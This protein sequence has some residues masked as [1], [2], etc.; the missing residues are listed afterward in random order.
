MCHGHTGSNDNNSDLK[1]KKAFCYVKKKHLDVQAVETKAQIK[2]LYDNGR[3]GFRF[4]CKKKKKKN[5]LRVLLLSTVQADKISK[6]ALGDF[7]L[8]TLSL[9]ETM[10][11]FAPSFMATLIHSLMSTFRNNI[12]L[13]ACCFIF[14]TSSLYFNSL[15]SSD[16]NPAVPL[17]GCSETEKCCCPI[18]S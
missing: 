1:K 9:L 14:Y 17:F 16:L 11:V 15:Q 10:G 13:S 2:L 6:V 5:G 4:Y 12:L 3:M 8:Q 18:C 7:C